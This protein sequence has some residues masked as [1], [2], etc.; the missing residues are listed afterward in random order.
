MACEAIRKQEEGL[1]H[2][3]VLIVQQ[4]NDRLDA[5]IVVQDQYTDSSRDNTLDE[6]DGDPEVNGH[7]FDIYGR[8]RGWVRPE[9]GRSMMNIPISTNAMPLKVSPEPHYTLDGA[10]EGKLAG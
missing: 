4:S 6:Q 1:Q 2:M 9:I 7:S 10:P 8:L 5:P 3:D